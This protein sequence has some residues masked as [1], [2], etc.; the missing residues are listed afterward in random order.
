MPHSIAR[1]ASPFGLH[2]LAM[3]LSYSLRYYGSYSR[4]A[5]YAKDVRCHIQD[6]HVSYVFLCKTVSLAS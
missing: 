2:E 1:R 5:L 3:S 4:E 6:L